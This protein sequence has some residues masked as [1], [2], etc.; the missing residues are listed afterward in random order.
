MPNWH[1]CGKTNLG[2]LSVK[3]SESAQQGCVQD[4]LSGKTEIQQGGARFL[5][6]VASLVNGVHASSFTVAQGGFSGVKPNVQKL[7]KE[8][9][10]EQ[11]AVL[12]GQ[13][14][15]SN[16]LDLIALD[17]IEGR[18]F[19]PAQGGLEIPLT[20]KGLGGGRT[21]SQAGID[22]QINN[23]KVKRDQ[24]KRSLLLH[25]RVI[26]GLVGD[27]VS[28]KPSSQVFAELAGEKRQEKEVEDTLIASIET[29]E[30]EISALMQNIV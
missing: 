18:G 6:E 8:A 24:L 27:M 15:S 4:A 23:L 11:R 28:E 5:S 7:L 29:K 16:G 21:K 12:R 10:D 1:S 13:A 20:G 9:F 19:K 14:G 22:A 30:K 3:I 25:N 2:S 17:R 26:N